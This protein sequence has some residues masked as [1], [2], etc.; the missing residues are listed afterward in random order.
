MTGSGELGPITPGWDVQEY[1]VPVAIGENA[2]GAGSVS[3]SAAARENS[4][5]VINNNISTTEENLGK[6]SG[7]IK[8]V[9]QNGI[10]VSISH[11]TKLSIF[12]ASKNIPALGAGGIVPALDLCGQLAGMDF[13][14]NIPAG[15]FYSLQGHSAGFQS[16][17]TNA[18]TIVNDGSYIDYNPSSGNFFPIYY[19]EQ[20]GSIWAN[21]FEVFG[22]KIWSQYV[23]GDMFSNSRFIPSSRL[24]FKTILDSSSQ[25]TRFTFSALPDDS[26]TGSGQSINLTIDRDSEQISLNGNYRQ[27]GTLRAI[28]AFTDLPEGI[29]IDEELA[30]FIEYTRPVDDNTY[31]IKVRVSN[32]TDYENFA[33]IEVEFD[34]DYSE[35]H[36]NWYLYGRARSVYRHQG[37][38]ETEWI[39]VEYE[40]PVSYVI[41]SSI[42]LNGPVAAQKNTN[43]WEYIQAAC[44]AYHKEISLYDDVV[45][46]R[47]IGIREVDITNVVGAPTV[48]PSVILSGKNVEIDYTNSYN[49]DNQE[50]YNAYK[51]NNRVLSVKA[52]ETISTKVEI[53]GTPAFLRVPQRSTTPPAGLNEYCIVDSTG[54]QVPEELWEKYGGKLIVS[55]NPEILNAIDVTLT[56]PSSTDG[57]FNEIVSPPTP[58]L[59]P[60]PYKVAYSDG[61]NDYAALSIVGSGVKFS[62][63]T[64]RLLTGVDPEKV[65]TDVAKTISNAFISTQTQ[66]YDRGIWASLEASGPRVILSG[67]IPVQAQ[68]HFGLVAGSRIRYRDSI[69]RITEVRIGNL[70]VDF[71]AARHVTVED[72]DLL[73]S[74][75]SVG[76]H[77]AMWDGYDNSD[78]II[79]PL[80]FV[81]DDESVLMFLDTD[82]NPYYDF[83]GEPEISVFPDTD[84]N[85]YYEDGGNL[86]GQD[87]V[88]LDEDENP[89]DGGEGYGS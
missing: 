49:V 88:Y 16:D 25:Q 7:V 80:R 12:D 14:L 21:S 3:F 11:D 85:P 68:M 44:S 9:S 1:A 67:S 61:D 41:D 54:L 59:Y 86:E 51:D 31:F 75:K 20:Y 48:T 38:Y 15:N 50:L 64:L 65:S 81:G 42:D 29:N 28:D 45:T 46:V 30:V 24:A 19:R 32:T 79:A 35:Y 36:D 52:G 77:D 71:T 78:H 18:E 40:N 73:W 83:D 17:G 66:A 6:V 72:F 43:M 55:V 53:N 37:T 82:V 58:P 84:A 89:Y 5:F 39:P 74:G 69:Y 33:A 34:A 60:G 10:N 70:G 26:N 76:L 63:K 62:K 47:D 56:G 13:I 8:T 22:N 27:G 23:I 57:V 4:L 2:S 87:P